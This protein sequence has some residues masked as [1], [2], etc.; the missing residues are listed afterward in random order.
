VTLKNNDTQIAPMW[1]IREVAL[2]FTHSRGNKEHECKKENKKH[3][4]TKRTQQT[5]NDNEKTR[6]DTATAH[7]QI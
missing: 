1:S 4:L 7:I 5:I 2:A 6:P 3:L